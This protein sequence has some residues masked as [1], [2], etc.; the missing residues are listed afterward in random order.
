VIAAFDGEE[1]DRWRLRAFGDRF[2]DLVRTAER[3]A[4][5]LDDQRR[6]SERL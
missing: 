3:I 6:Y 1:L 4:R 2:L 5:A